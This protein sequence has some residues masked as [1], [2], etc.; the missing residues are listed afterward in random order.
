MLD[1]AVAA[2][3]MFA[4][5]VV[6][7]VEGGLPGDHHVLGKFQRHHDGVRDFSPVFFRK[8]AAAHRGSAGLRQIQCGLNPGDLVHHVF[9]DVPAGKFPEQAPVDEFVG[10]ET[11]VGPPV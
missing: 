4:Q 5:S 2:E 7:V 3:Q 8:D 6:A 9:G 1:G 11:A 10:I